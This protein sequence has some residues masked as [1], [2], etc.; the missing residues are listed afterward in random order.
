MG[1]SDKPQGG[2]DTGTQARDLIGLMDA[3]PR[4]GPR[5]TGGVPVVICLR[6]RDR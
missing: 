5:H 3:P 4:S 6:T 1:L 2:Y